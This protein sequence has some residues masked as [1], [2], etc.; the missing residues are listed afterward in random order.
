MSAIRDMEIS[1]AG[2]HGLASSPTPR[3]RQ[4]AGTPS[5]KG[6]Q[7]FCLIHHVLVSVSQTDKKTDSTAVMIDRTDMIDRTE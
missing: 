7:T 5:Q 3:R 2:I 6:R 4:K 1:T